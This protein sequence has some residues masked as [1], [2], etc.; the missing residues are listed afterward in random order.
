M[1]LSFTNRTYGA[2]V[3]RS[4]ALASANAQRIQRT[5]Q[6][7]LRLLLVRVP[8][9]FSSYL[10][11]PVLTFAVRSVWIYQYTKGRVRRGKAEKSGSEIEE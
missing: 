2:L 3:L 1:V 7:S 11:Q 4:P 6:C 5:V 9:S 10:D 8:V